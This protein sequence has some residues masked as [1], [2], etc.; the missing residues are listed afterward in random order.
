MAD[1]IVPG[2]LLIL[3]LIGTVINSVTEKHDVVDEK[4]TR[5]YN[6]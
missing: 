2:I 5:R 4:K 3:F 6:R 1:W